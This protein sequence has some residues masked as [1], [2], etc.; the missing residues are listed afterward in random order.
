MSQMRQLGL[1]FQM[2]AGDHNDML[3]PAVW[4]NPS[5]TISWDS[6]INSVYRRE[7]FPGGPVGWRFIAR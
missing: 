7:R 1:G 2:F 5:Y 3:P 4:Q 6:Y